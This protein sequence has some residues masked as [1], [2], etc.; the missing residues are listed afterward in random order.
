MERLAHGGGLYQRAPLPECRTHVLSGKSIGSRPQCQLSR[1]HYLRLHA[2]D[3]TTDSNN[4][5]RLALRK[6]VPVQA[7]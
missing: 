2:A 7:K 6:M 1:S 3:V 4:V 5:R